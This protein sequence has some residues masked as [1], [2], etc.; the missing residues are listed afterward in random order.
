MKHFSKLMGQY[1]IYISRLRV[2]QEHERCTT[3]WVGRDVLCFRG[4]S[5]LPLFV[6]SAMN[7]YVKYVEMTGT[8]AL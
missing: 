3:Q 6:R 1:M 7:I 5:F 4:S 2:S 8:I